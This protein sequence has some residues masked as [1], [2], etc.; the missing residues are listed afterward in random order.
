LIVQPKSSEA[1]SIHVEME[2]VVLNGT[3]ESVERLRDPTTDRRVRTGW[4][5]VLCVMRFVCLPSGWHMC[6]FLTL[7]MY[8]LT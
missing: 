6:R 4:D 5:T 2:E 1:L 3:V 7:T 8:T